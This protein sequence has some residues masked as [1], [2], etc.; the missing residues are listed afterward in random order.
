LPLRLI[1]GNNTHYSNHDDNTTSTTSTT[2]SL[3]LYQVGIATLIQALESAKNILTKAQE[4]PNA[5]SFPAARIH[6]DMHPL[7]FQIAVMAHFASSTAHKVAGKDLAGTGSWEYFD[8]HTWED[9]HARLDQAADLLRSIKPED[10]NGREDEVIGVD[11]KHEGQDRV[12]KVT[13][14]GLIL[15]SILPNFLFHL[16]AAYAILRK[17]GVPVGKHDYIMPFLKDFGA[18]LV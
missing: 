2:M 18:E 5:A 9:M 10:V 15:G 7:T 12:W 3:N 14:T 13:C 8:L 1:T 17:E 16:T 4:H 6:P 11:I